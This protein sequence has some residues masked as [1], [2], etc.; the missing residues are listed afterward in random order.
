MTANEHLIRDLVDKYGRSR[1]ALIP[2]LQ[3][4]V[5][6]KNFISD[7]DMTEIAKELDLSAAQVY[8]T[9]TF[10]S[11]LSTKPLGKY[12]IRVCKTITCDMHG[13]KQIVQTIEEM[14]KVKAGETTPNKKFSL[15][16]T[17]CLGWCHEGPAML[18]NEKPYTGLTPE[19]VHDIISEYINQS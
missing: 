10:Y 13:K 19:R 9:A 16:E 6:V 1:T 2:I 15:L 4:V 14:L 12:V 8:G 7:S 5:E 11:F 3:G 18:I 17:N